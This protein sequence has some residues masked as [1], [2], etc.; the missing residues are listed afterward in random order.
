[1]ELNARY[2]HFGSTEVLFAIG[3]KSAQGS[4]TG[5]GCILHLDRFTRIFD[6]ARAAAIEFAAAFC[7]CPNASAGGGASRR[8]S[9]RIFGRLRYNLP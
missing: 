2:T 6:T 7:V 8:R 5:A 4:C 3:T 9:D 1:M